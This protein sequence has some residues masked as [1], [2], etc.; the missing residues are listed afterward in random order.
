MDPRRVE[1]RLLVRAIQVV[2]SLLVLSLL[3]L[4]AL[5][6]TLRYTHPS[7]TLVDRD[8]ALVEAEARVRPQDPELRVA[9]AN[10]LL[11]KGRLEDAIEQAYQVH[12]MLPGHAGA[13]LVLASAHVRRGRA[14][15]AIGSL[16]TTA[17]ANRENPLGRA[18]LQLALVNQLLGRLHLEQ[19][20]PSRAIQPLR[21]SLAADRANAETLY[22]LGKAHAASGE[23]QE[24]VTHLRRALRLVPDFA[25]AHAELEQLYASLGQP[26]LALFARGMIRL[27]AGDYAAAIE[28]LRNA[29]EALPDTTETRL[30]LA[31]AYERS[32]RSHDAF[33]QYLRALEL[34][35]NSVAARQ[36]LGRLSGQS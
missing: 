24:A 35:A 17:A 31:M 20:Q 1:E 34:D 8:L 2:G 14:D 10:L 28:L 33:D 12:E 7:L 26:D 22:L 11:E 21:E 15:L 16:S 18:S 23:P 19:G 6:L 25:E 13:S 9:L 36:A 32:G 5:Y 30:G 29:A 27:S 4:A 3:G